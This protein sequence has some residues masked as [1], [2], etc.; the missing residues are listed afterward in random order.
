[1]ASKLEIAFLWTIN[2][3]NE[4]GIDEYFSTSIDE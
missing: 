2:I 1:M 3:E 4:V